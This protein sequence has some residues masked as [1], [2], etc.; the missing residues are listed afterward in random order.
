MVK[1]RTT[2][3]LDLIDILL[4]V[5]ELTNRDLSAVSRSLDLAKANIA[6]DKPATIVRGQELYP[7]MPEKMAVLAESLLTRPPFPSRQ[8]EIAFLAIFELARRNGY[9]WTVRLTRPDVA[10]ELNDHL[11]QL[12]DGS[13]GG[14][15]R[16]AHWISD[17]LS[18]RA[19]IAAQVS[20][21]SEA[22][23]SS[24]PPTQ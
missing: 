17:R 24:L 1:L 23:R 18:R 13:S 7:S 2:H 11:L 14:H 22:G 12:Q 9:R 4:V 21:I 3:H 10:R 16:F 20:A 15:R 8:R 19:G 5:S 6:V